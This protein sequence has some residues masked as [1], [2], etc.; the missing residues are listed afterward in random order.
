MNMSERT[1]AGVSAGVLP[2]PVTPRRPPSKSE[3]PWSPGNLGGV[4]DA[5]KMLSQ[6]PGML[7]VL[8]YPKQTDSLYAHGR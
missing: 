1:A 2:D 6:E 8:V 5:G 7:T 3:G 4:S